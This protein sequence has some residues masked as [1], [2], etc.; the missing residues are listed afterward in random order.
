MNVR[1]IGEG[2]NKRKPNLEPYKDVN[3]SRFNVS[4][5][6]TMYSILLVVL[7]TLLIVATE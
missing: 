6:I 2:R 4:Y 5:V 3:D 7:F 1:S